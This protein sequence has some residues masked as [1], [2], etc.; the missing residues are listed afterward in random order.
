MLSIKEILWA[1]LVGQFYFLHNYFQYY[2]PISTS[3]WGKSSDGSGSKIYDPGRVGS[4]FCGLGRV[5]S[6]IYGMGL[7]LENFP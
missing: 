5:G 3:N 1:E 4:I 7:N 6:A 2:C